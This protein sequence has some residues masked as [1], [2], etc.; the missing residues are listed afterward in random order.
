MPPKN[1]NPLMQ[2]AE[3]AS[4]G[5]AMVAATLVGLFF[6]LYLDRHFGTAPILTLVFLF[7]GIAAGFRIMYQDYVRYFKEDDRHD[8]E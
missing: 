2:M 6:G 7:F 1:Q 8:D 5:I 4:L 3:L